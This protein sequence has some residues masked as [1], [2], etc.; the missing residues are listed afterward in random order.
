M[1]KTEPIP[2]PTSLLNSMG[3]VDATP[4]DIK[5]AGVDRKIF[6]A[7]LELHGLLKDRQAI[8]PMNQEKLLAVVAHYVRNGSNRGGNCAT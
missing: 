4:E 6:L 2:I 5:L 1:K 3:L 7:C 8:K